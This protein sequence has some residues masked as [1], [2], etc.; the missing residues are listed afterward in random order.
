MRIYY[1]KEQ[2][3]ERG[4]TDNFFRVSLGIEDIDDL[5]RDFEEA[6]KVLN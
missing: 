4:Y 1:T 5:I 6:L 3:I 2:Q